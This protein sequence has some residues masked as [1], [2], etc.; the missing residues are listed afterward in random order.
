MVYMKIGIAGEHIIIKENNKLLLFNTTDSGLYKIDP[1]TEKLLI[2]IKK[3]GIEATKEL[4][5]G[6]D[7]DNVAEG[8]IAEL[9]ENGFLDPQPEF[10][11]PETFPITGA[12]LNVCHD[13]NL[14]CRYCYGGGGTYVGEKCYMSKEVGELSI[15]RL[16]EW[17]GDRKMVYITFFG[18]EPLLNFN[19]IK[20]LVKYGKEKARSENKKIKFS[21]TSNCTLLTDKII[22][23]LNKNNINVLAS[24]DG[25]KSVQDMN[26]PFRNGKGSY[27]IVAS[28]VQKLIATRNTVTARATLTRDCISL[29]TIINGLTEVGFRYIHIEPVTADNCSFA[30]SEKDFEKLK[31]EYE[32]IGKLLL[33]SIL[34]GTPFGFSNIL[35]TMNVI[36]N[37]T[38]R[39]YPCGAGKNLV[40]IDANGGIYLCH[41]F[42]GMGEFFMGTLQNPDFSLQKEILQK[43]VDNRKSCRDCWA[44]H[45]CGGSCWHENYYYTGRIDTPYTPRC[46]LF[47]HIA[48]LSMIIFSKIHEK[49]KELLDK[50]FQK[51]ESFHR[52]DLPEDKQNKRR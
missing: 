20:H 46:D 12:S 17:S 10:T 6:E 41:R 21:M 35:R 37:S 25:P 19:L 42:T 43:H 1:I 15:D 11:P 30:L 7:V 36:Y 34:N 47:K 48:A 51:H 26:R 52:Q 33:K 49:D 5:K 38:V 22:D 29:G 18:G 23:F 45:L 32:N 13:C 8:K 24:M 44:R 28:N 16:L 31:K 4:M 27:D 2:L 39:Y 40:G 9:K 50:M 3:H 14:S